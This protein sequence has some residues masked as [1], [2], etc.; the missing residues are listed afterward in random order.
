MLKARKVL[1]KSLR[2]EL[3]RKARSERGLNIVETHGRASLRLNHAF[4]L[5][6]FLSITPK[7]FH[8]FITFVQTKTIEVIININSY[9]KR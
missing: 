9:G 2:E 8:N 5:F 6:I 3:K 1:V 7:V 4:N